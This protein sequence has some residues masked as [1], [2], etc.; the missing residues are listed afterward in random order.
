LR[1]RERKILVAVM[2]EGSRS[3]IGEEEEEEEREM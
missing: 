1:E 3:L 2:R